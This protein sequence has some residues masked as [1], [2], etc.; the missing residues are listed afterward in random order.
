MKKLI[1]C[2]LSWGILFFVSV[3]EIDGQTRIRFARGR[4]STSVS[5]TL[6]SIGER[7]FILRAYEGQYLSANV[8]SRGGCIKFS[9]VTTSIRYR[10]DAGDNWIKLMNMC[11]RSATFTMT[12]SIQ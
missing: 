7:D 12:V 1:S 5:G 6:G 4:T 9:Q 11:R 10:T 3:L 8:S 2:V